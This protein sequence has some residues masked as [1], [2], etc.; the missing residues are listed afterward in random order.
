LN[1]QNSDIYFI[2]RVIKP[3]VVKLNY[4]ELQ[5]EEGLASTSITSNPRERYYHRQMALHAS[6]N[7]SS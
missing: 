6:E 3:R 7:I 1:I 4:D 2:S 5:E